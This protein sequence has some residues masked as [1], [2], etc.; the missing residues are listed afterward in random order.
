MDNI[1]VKYESDISGIN[2]ASEALNTLKN[3]EQ[4][5]LNKIKELEQNK[6]YWSNSVKG[7]SA[8][9]KVEQEFSKE[10]SNTKKELDSTRKSIAQL[11][12]SHKDLDANMMKGAAT[13]SLKGRLRELKEDL[14][15]MEMAGDDS[16]QRFV[17]L[18]VEAGKLSDQIGD[19]NAQISA[20]ASDT[21]GLD[22]AMGVG[23][24]LT[25][26]FTAATSA[27]AL[28]GGE[29]EELQKAF[30]KVQAAL[31]LL[32]GVQ[33]VANVLNKDSAATV[34]IRNSLSKLFTR[35]KVAE[36]TA[37]TAHTVATG[38]ETAATTAATV[39]TK[40]FTKAL[41]ANPV[42]WIVA[43]IMGAVFAISKLV[44]A[45][46]AEAKE[47]EKLNALTSVYLENLQKRN[48]I[49]KQIGDERVSIIENE[50]KV[51]EAAGASEQ[52]LAVMEEKILDK[53]LKNAQQ[54]A[55]A[56]QFAMG[57]IDSNR[58]KVISLTEALDKMASAKNAGKG[59]F[60]Y[61]IK[62]MFGGKEYTEK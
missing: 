29:N 28:L 50:K 44:S 4:E 24:G 45:M 34:V 40:G 7:T 23:Q 58:M 13:K 33:M 1:V 57:Q 5:L 46:N 48:D 39:A 36:T 16:S 55:D 6:A 32:S 17:D 20:L 21:K 41:L 27:A 3:R 42:F 62:Y 19:T 51:M 47:Q 18:S 30:F 53:R 31:Q 56:N 12:E 25:G 49:Q 43:V 61:E 15:A 14:Q 52:E 59:K 10:L 11:V 37:T 26:A 2:E 54:L 60:E 22:A 9:I 35:N 38:A 8:Q